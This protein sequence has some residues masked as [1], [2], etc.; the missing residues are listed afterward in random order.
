MRT[1]IAIDAS[2]ALRLR[3][4]E[5]Q[6]RI[7]K[8]VPNLKFV[9]DHQL[10][11]T[12]K[13]LGDMDAEPNGSDSGNGPLGELMRQLASVSR[14]RGPFEIVPRELGTFG[15]RGSVSVLWAGFSDPSGELHRLHS[16]LEWGLSQIGF[17]PEDR[18]FKPH[19]TLARSKNPNLSR[20]ILKALAG[21]PPFR[22][23]PM[24]VTSMTLYESTLRP[25]GPVHTVLAS[26]EFVGQAGRG[27]AN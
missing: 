20:H 5:T 25:E 23:A 10:H 27:V 16:D 26:Y 12:L 11:L 21:E 13:F 19:L 17:P 15:P 8:A 7:R 24:R 9:P 1:F 18:P 3:L 6:S 4:S 14:G 22:L 2:E